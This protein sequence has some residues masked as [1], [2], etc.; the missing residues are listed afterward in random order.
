MICKVVLATDNNASLELAQVSSFRLL[1]RS[2]LTN[3]VE[4]GK[5]KKVEMEGRQKKKARACSSKPTLFLAR[6]WNLTNFVVQHVRRQLYSSLEVNNQNK[7]SILH[8]KDVLL[9]QGHL[10]PSRRQVYFFPR[11]TG[12]SSPKRCLCNMLANFSISQPLSPLVGGALS[13][14]PPGW[15][16]QTTM[17]QSSSA[18][19]MEP[20]PAHVF[21]R[22]RS[23]RVLLKTVAIEESA[24]V[25]S[26]SLTFWL[27]RA[28]GEQG[29]ELRHRPIGHLGR[30]MR[31]S[32]M[33]ECRRMRERLAPGIPTTSRLN[34]TSPSPPPNCHAPTCRAAQ[35]WVATISSQPVWRTICLCDDCGAVPYP[36]SRELKPE[37]PS[38]ERMRMRM[39]P[40]IKAPP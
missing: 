23:A 14:D 20:L 33:R 24:N 22:H 8:K 18:H 13:L 32:S 26:S 34:S 27:R 30:R 5:W 40:E 3:V 10:V 1:S 28:K 39:P 17:V 21:S 37:A 16:W 31:A 4:S 35:P 6:I 12:K 11:L 36:G 15:S 7:Q 2:N 25:P 38:L 19:A 29:G 9:F